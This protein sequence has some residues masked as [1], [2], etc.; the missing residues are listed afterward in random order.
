MDTVSYFIQ[1]RPHPGAPWQR[2][3]VGVDCWE[4]KTTALQRLAARREGQPT[5]E[6]R[7][8]E[9]ITS[10]TEQPPRRRDRP[11]ATRRQ[12]SAGGASGVSGRFGS[13]APRRRTEMVDGLRLSRPW[14]PEARSPRDRL[15]RLVA[16]PGPG[17]CRP[18][19]GHPLIRTFKTLRMILM[20]DALAT[21]TQLLDLASRGAITDDP[22]SL[23]Q[24]LH[25]AHGLYCAGIDEVRTDTFRRCVDLSEEEVA[26]RCRQAGAPWEIGM[27]RTEAVADLAFTLWDTSPAALAYGKIAD[28][29]VEFGVG[30]V[31]SRE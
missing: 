1:S 13:L 10:V 4:S 3:A 17:R 26:T 7:L 30:L 27:T 15:Q 14:P 22:D 2:P 21:T 12:S 25:K 31:P 9:R 6:H 28:R 11:C 18:G 23:R 29:A 20:S 5:W 16:R 19:S 24:I 8:M